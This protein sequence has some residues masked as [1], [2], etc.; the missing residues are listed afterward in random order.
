MRGEKWVSLILE[1]VKL[2][3]AC[4]PGSR[5]RMDS[6]TGEEEEENCCRRMGRIEGSIRAPR[7]PKHFEK[8]NSLMLHLDFNI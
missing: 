1:P 5:A 7:R 4:K 3:G 8:G 2:F 6:R